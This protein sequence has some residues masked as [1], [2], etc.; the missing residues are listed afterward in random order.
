MKKVGRDPGK[1]PISCS[2]ILFGVGLLLGPGCMIFEGSNIDRRSA[3]RALGSL[4][5]QSQISSHL[6]SC[7]ITKDGGFGS[8]LMAIEIAINKG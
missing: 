2:V 6:W 7:V 4:P 5:P 1:S 3:K 8:S